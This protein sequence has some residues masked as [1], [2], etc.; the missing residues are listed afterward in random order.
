M[1]MVIG[2]SALN[3]RQEKVKVSA[4]RLLLSAILAMS[5]F[6]NLSWLRSGKLVGRR[7]PPRRQM[8]GP[9]DSRLT[10]FCSFGS[11]RRQHLL[12]A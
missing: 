2:Q 11:A 7:V 9:P 1:R 4:N 3:K 5:A 8:H 10:A 12:S 6:W